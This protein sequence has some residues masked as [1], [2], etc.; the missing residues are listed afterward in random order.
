[1]G[2]HRHGGHD[3]EPPTRRFWKL[4]QASA[5]V[6]HEKA[7]IEQ[8]G[9]APLYA[10]TGTIFPTAHEP[11]DCRTSAAEG[12][13]VEIT[14]SK[15]KVITLTANE[16]GNFFYKNFDLVFPYYAKVIF[17]GRERAMAPQPRNV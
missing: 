15:G 4:G 7:N 13:V 5:E 12:A 8:G 10:M 6:H 11:D 1:M 2:A 14:D 9:D 17:E 16:A 3:H